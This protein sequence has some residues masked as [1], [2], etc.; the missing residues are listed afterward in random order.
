MVMEKIIL[1]S[2]VVYRFY[3]LEG[4]FIESGVELENGQFYVVVGRDKFKKL[5]YSELIFDK[6][7]MR[8]FF[9]QKV[10]LLFFIVGFRKFKGSGNDC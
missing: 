1:R 8:R 4:K 6:L 7:I 2:G 5:F 9:G 10:F 3:I